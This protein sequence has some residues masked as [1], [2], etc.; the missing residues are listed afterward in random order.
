MNFK[1]CFIGGGNMASSMIA[2]V[3]LD[4]FNAKNI[5]VYDRNK[6][7]LQ[8]LVNKYGINIS[9]DLQKTVKEADMVILS[10]K[11]QQMSDIVEQISQI[12]INHKKFIVTVAAGLNVKFYQSRLNSLIAIARVMPNTPSSVQCGASGVYYNNN[13]SKVQKDQIEYILKTMGVYIVLD[14]E[15]KI[16]I[17]AAC[18]GSAPAYFFK[19]ME[20]IIDEA[21]LMG[22]TE[23]QARNIVTMTMLGTA[24]MAISS[25]DKIS[26][27]RKNVTSKG[28]TTA[29]ALR[30]FNE[31]K[32]DSIIAEAMRANV[33][34]SEEMSNEMI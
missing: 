23:Q 17:V 3:V 11:P 2:G 27:L 13:V 30:V 25:G 32:L 5:T 8:N 33:K 15:S 20:S 34:R 28:G 4:G 26:T 21:V 1:I 12:V 16:N 10:V 14:S 31:N 19:F 7:K 6:D 18:A 24:K 22:I 29:E 9:Q